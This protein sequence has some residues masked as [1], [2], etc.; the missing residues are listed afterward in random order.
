MK[1]Q[2]SPSKRL[3][4]PEA[5]LIPFLLRARSLSILHT[6]TYSKK[7]IKRSGIIK[8]RKYYSIIS[9]A[10]AKHPSIPY[11]RLA[12]L[13]HSDRPFSTTLPCDCSGK[14][15][16]MRNRNFIP[17]ETP[18]SF[19]VFSLANYPLLPSLPHSP[20]PW[21][22]STRACACNEGT[23]GDECMRRERK[24]WATGRGDIGINCGKISLPFREERK[25]TK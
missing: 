13:S 7:L 19:L 8:S 14:P 3:P 24:G 23:R 4:N 5:L 2:I 12:F 22:R 25:S 16:T 15:P 6:P 18:R 9:L 1:L 10:R 21:L 20:A 17:R 11:T